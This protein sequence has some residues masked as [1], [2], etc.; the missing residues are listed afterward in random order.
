MTMTRTDLQQAWSDAAQSGTLLTAKHHPTGLSTTYV[1]YRSVLSIELANNLDGFIG[2]GQ[3]TIDSYQ[4]TKY[5]KSP[6]YYVVTPTNKQFSVPSSGV[7]GG[8]QTPN[9]A[10]DTLVFVSGSKQGWHCYGE[11]STA[12]QKNVAAKSLTFNQR[13]V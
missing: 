5:P 6:A 2:S 10:Y 4:N 9:A 7:P 11:S 1:P 8:S 13:I 3:Y 12:I